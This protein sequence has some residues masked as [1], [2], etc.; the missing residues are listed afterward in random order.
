M[1]INVAHVQELKYVHLNNLVQAL[2]DDPD[3]A[4]LPG[5]Q[6]ACTFHCL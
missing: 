1:Q 3:L 5:D 2:K 6:V 4:S